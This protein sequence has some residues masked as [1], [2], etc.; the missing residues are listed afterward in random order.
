MSAFLRTFIAMA[1]LA[2]LPSA[3]AEARN[4][5][6]EDWGTTQSGEKVSRRDADPARQVVPAP[7]V[8]GPARG[9]EPRRQLE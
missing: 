1:C 3:A 9:G 4:I 2:T 8:G 6:G 7:K 5:T